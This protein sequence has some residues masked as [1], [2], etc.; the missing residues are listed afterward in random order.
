MQPFAQIQ[1]ISIKN[2]RNKIAVIK[3][4]FFFYFIGL[5]YVYKYLVKRKLSIHIT[6]Y[7]V[8]EAFHKIICILVTLY[9]GKWS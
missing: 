6:K 2:K 7:E 3:I 1:I 4:I 8:V 5:L 9:F